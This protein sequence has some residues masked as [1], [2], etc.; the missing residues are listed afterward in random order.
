MLKN[1][2]LLLL[3]VLMLTGCAVSNPDLFPS[4][5]EERPVEVV[6][7][8]HG[9]HVG[10]ALPVDS[11]FAAV[12]HPDLHA[13]EYRFAEFG[14]GDRDFYT[15]NSRSLWTKLKGALWSTPSVVHI[16]AFDLHPDVQFQGLSRQSVRLSTDG[17]RELLYFIKQ[18][19][20]ADESGAPVELQPGLYANGIF[21]TSS[22][23]YFWP[24]TSNTWVARLLNEAGAPISPFWSPN[25]GSVM[26]QS[27][28]LDARL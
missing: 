9:W 15:G 21:Y 8:R 3:A 26:R 10:L 14:W 18:T 19:L 4:D 27:R 5:V 28:G 24:R 16:A 6:I 25:A 23:G 20:D 13:Q 12:L 1:L 17:Y 22:R 7:V 2:P 11:T